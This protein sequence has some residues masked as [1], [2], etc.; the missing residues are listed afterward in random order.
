MAAVE[1]LLRVGQVVTFGAGK[2]RW[3]VTDVFFYERLHRD[4]VSSRSM[5]L[6]YFR[7][8][9]SRRTTNRWHDQLSTVREVS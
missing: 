7:S 8:R 2:T 4:S 1:P 9:D 3:E 5:W 6:Y